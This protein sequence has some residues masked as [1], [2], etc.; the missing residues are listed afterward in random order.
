M[1]QGI[2]RKDA[3]QIVQ[4]ACRVRI[5]GV[6]D[7]QIIP[8]HRHGDIGKIF[9]A[10]GYKPGECK[11]IEQGFIDSKGNFYS[12]TSAMKHVREIHQPLILRGNFNT[13]KQLFSEDL[14]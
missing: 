3:P 13:G 14:Y 11:I 7:Y 2:R 1:D 8:L 4:A 9:K 10:F 6:T 5:P 12:R